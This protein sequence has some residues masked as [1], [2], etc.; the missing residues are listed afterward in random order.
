MAFVVDG[1]G[2]VIQFADFI[3]VQDLDQRVFEA[4][5]G[6]TEIVVDEMLVKSTDRIV[7]KI[8][9]SEW[10]REYLSNVGSGYT[11]LAALDTPDK[12][13]F[14]R[15][16]DFTD[17]C[18][19]HTLSSYLYPK[20]ANF[21]DPDSAEVQKIAFYERRFQELYNELISMG[22]FYDLDEDGT[23]ETNE[24]YTKFALTR[25]TRGRKSIVRVK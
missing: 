19:F 21:G 11:S 18:C 22:D 2:N 14:Q 17:L 6:L 20:I 1:S 8:K 4:N 5:E 7:Q 25:R 12:N 9:S 23:V 24:K 15:R 13:K 16:V 10:W 3:D